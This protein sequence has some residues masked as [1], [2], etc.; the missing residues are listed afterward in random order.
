MRH[1]RALPKGSGDF[2]SLYHGTFTFSTFNLPVGTYD[3]SLHNNIIISQLDYADCC[4][5][6]FIYVCVFKMI[7]SSMVNKAPPLPPLLYNLFFI[8][9]KFW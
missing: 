8:C 4:P 3:S 2:L 7:V 9:I 1:T 5:G 6:K